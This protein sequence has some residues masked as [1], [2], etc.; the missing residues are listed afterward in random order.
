MARR[1][2]SEAWTVLIRYKDDL[3]TGIGLA[4][5]AVRRRLKEIINRFSTNTGNDFQPCM[6]PS[7]LAYCWAG[8]E[9]PLSASRCLS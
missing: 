2:G 4:I 5:N 1:E 8:G 6:E 9:I 7:Y 3:A